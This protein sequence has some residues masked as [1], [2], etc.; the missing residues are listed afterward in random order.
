MQIKILNQGGGGGGTHLRDH[1]FRLLIAHRDFVN[2]VLVTEVT[3]HLIWGIKHL[4]QVR[5]EPKAS[6]EIIIQSKGEQGLHL[7]SRASPTQA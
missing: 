6:T 7:S 4:T 1:R 3:H 2:L 5:E